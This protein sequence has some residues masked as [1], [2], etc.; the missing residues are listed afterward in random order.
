ML[1]AFVVLSL[2]SEG[3]PTAGRAPMDVGSGDPIVA[4]DF[5]GRDMGEKITR[6]VA[7]CPDGGC[8]VAVPRGY[9]EFSS[10]VRITKPVVIVGT[11][12]DS[13]ALA[14]SGDGDAIEIEAGQGAGYLTGAIS[15]LSVIG[16]RGSQAVGV[17]QVDTIGFRYDE[18]VVAGFSVG[19][20]VDNEPASYCSHCAAD[21]NERT[22]L[23]KVSFYNNTTGLKFQVAPGASASFGYTRLLDSDFQVPNGGVGIEL[24]GGANL[25]NS[26]L[27]FS[28]NLGAPS[29]FFYLHDASRITDSVCAG[30]AEAFPG[31]AGDGTY[32][33]TMDGSSEF[34]VSG[35][36][37]EIGAGERLAPGARY[38]IAPYRD[39]PLQA[40]GTG[41]VV[42]ST[43]ATLAGATLEDALVPGSSALSVLGVLDVRGGILDVPGAVNTPT[44]VLS[45]PS[46]DDT[47]VGA[48]A[49]QVLLN[50]ELKSPKLDGPVIGGESI[51]APSHPALGIFIP[52]AATRR[53]LAA[54]WTPD[55]RG[56]ITRLEATV[57]VAPEGCTDD[58]AV[59]V[60]QAGRAVGLKIASSRND[61]GPISFAVS[62]GAPLDVWV[63]PGNCGPEAHRKVVRPGR[64]G[65]RPASA[66]GGDPG[67]GRPPGD[68]NLIIQFRPG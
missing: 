14:Y 43:G 57:R 66:R 8:T 4:S 59:S 33:V 9:F 17:H 68:I 25:Y 49:A 5:A 60:V 18:L 61:S 41:E 27:G 50:K 36:C 62:E 6:A 37:R 40:T 22:E 55:H 7:S 63:T 12:P 54:S 21:Y 20:L 24:S 32:F 67:L 45:F 53:W 39:P 1:G 47:L 42:R 30:G 34:V 38:S 44:G 52:G 16:G 48:A 3:A 15:N 2:A 64:G 65:G 13:T 46:G 35:M 58:A 29:S 31:P 28:G 26:Y 23:G 51:S 56:F 11:G 10:T 19:M